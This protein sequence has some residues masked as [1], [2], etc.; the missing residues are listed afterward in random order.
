MDQGQFTVR[1]SDEPKKDDDII[2]D[3]FLSV[4]LSD[5]QNQEPALKQEHR[6]FDET[7]WIKKS[8]KK[9]YYSDEELEVCLKP[10]LPKVIAFN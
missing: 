3:D 2:E 4:K 7:P 10:P 8:S 9:Q 5:G 6:L 1:L